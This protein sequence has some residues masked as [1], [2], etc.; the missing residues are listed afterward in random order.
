ML[1]CIVTPHA[2]DMHNQQHSSAMPPT[3][4][5]HLYSHD[6]A[7]RRRVKPLVERSIC[8]T[9][10][11]HESDCCTGTSLLLELTTIDDVSCSLAF[12]D[13]SL[14]QRQSNHQHFSWLATVKSHVAHFGV[15]GHD[16]KGVKNRR[17][18]WSIGAQTGNIEKHSPWKKTALLPSNMVVSDCPNLQLCSFKTFGVVDVSQHDAAGGGK[19]E[20]T[21][22]PAQRVLHM[23]FIGR[24]GVLQ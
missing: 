5:H 8:C 23:M 11:Q 17:V 14:G 12:H 21:Y 1:K 9:A 20:K 2:N 10:E 6:V 16:S 7:Q 18:P 22:L 15:S 13:L 19:G 3:T 24:L 4:Q